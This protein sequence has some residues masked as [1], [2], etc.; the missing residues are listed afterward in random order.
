MRAPAPAASSIRAMAARGVATDEITP[1]RGA[2]IVIS[3][4]LLILPRIFILGFAIFSWKILIDAFSGWVVWVAGF[5]LLPWTTITYM[6]MW[7]IYSDR[8]YGVEWVFVAVAFVLD[9][10][11][12]STLRDR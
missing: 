3:L 5:F 9:L 10:I 7:G 11:T 8:V 4:A 2:E 6:M 12:W 1:L